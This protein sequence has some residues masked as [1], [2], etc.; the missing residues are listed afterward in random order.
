MTTLDPKPPRVAPAEKERPKHGFWKIDPETYDPLNEEFHCVD[1]LEALK[2]ENARLLKLLHDQYTGENWSQ[3]VKETREVLE[4]HGEQS[5][6][7]GIAD[8][9]LWVDASL[10]WGI[11]DWDKLKTLPGSER[12]HPIEA[13]KMRST[14]EKLTSSEWGDSSIQTRLWQQALFLAKTLNA[15]D[16]APA[17]YWSDDRGYLFLRV[18]DGAGKN[19]AV[20]IAPMEMLPPRK[21]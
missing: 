18:V 16:R 6:L 4:M 14:P 2:A 13:G 1:W 12:I 19:L 10:T 20:A 5:N 3:T 7:H 11:V 15:Q 21:G 9:L 8:C 17:D